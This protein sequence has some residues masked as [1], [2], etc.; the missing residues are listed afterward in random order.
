LKPETLQAAMQCMSAAFRL[1]GL[2]LVLLSCWVLCSA[3]QRL[4]AG[5]RGEYETRRPALMLTLIV[6]L[7]VVVAIAGIL[8]FFNNGAAA[9]T[10][11]RFLL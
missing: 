1:A 8:L 5:A 9:A 6:A 3:A 10:A 4:R 7:A 11:L 2:A